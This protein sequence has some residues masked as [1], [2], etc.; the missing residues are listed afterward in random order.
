MVSSA[1][2]TDEAAASDRPT[3][4]S[5][6]I[7]SPVAALRVRATSQAPIAAPPARPMMKIATTMLKA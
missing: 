7:A 1:Q 4:I 5:M 3:L 2:S 6:P